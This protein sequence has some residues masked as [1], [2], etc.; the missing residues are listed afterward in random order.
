MGILSSAL[1][2]ARRWLTHWLTSLALTTF[3]LF[4]LLPF[5]GNALF[6]TLDHL[7][8]D[9][10]VQDYTGDP[11]PA[12][13]VVV[14]DLGPDSTIDE[15]TEVLRKVAL[16]RP[17]SVGIDFVDQLT[18]GA[19]GSDDP[20]IVRFRQALSALRS[21]VAIPVRDPWL[22]VAIRNLPDVHE[23]SP[24]LRKD[25]DGVVRTTQMRVC[26]D[27]THDGERTLPT[28]AAAV[29]RERRPLGKSVTGCETTNDDRTPIL[30]APSEP[31]TPGRQWIRLLPKEN[32][33]QSLASLDD[34]YVIIGV[35]ASASKT[36][37]FETP[38][39]RLPGVLVHADAVWTFSTTA[40]ERVGW[41]TNLL[42]AAP[43]LFVG[44]ISGAVFAVFAVVR[45][46][47]SEIEG[48]LSAVK[49]LAWGLGALLFSGVVLFI[50]GVLW[51]WIAVAWLR[52]G[53]AA[54]ALAAVFGSMLETLIHAG[55]DVVGPLHWTVERGINRLLAFFAMTLLYV[56][57]SPFVAHA[58]TCAYY[59]T[60]DSNGEV[61]SIPS[62][63][64]PEGNPLWRPFERIH[65]KA[66]VSIRVTPAE[67]S[68]G[69]VIDLP[70]QQVDS[71]FV[72]PP[73]PQEGGLLGAWHSFW[74][75]LNPRAST[76]ASGA[77]ILYKGTE[78]A[79]QTARHGPLRKLPSLDSATGV[80]KGMKGF[81]LGWA[82]GQPPFIINFRD[83]ADD[84]LL[85]R[86]H[87]ADRLLWLPGQEAP[88]KPFV[89][90]VED[91]D[92][93]I[94][95]HDFRLLP[96][97][98]VDATAG[99]AGAIE[100]FVLDPTYRMEAFRRLSVRSE[101]G[102]VTAEQA[103]RLICLEEAK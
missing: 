102:D 80:V 82:G 55:E 11:G 33:D 39:G 96:P 12:H 87:T 98:S 18:L 100:L 1:W 21:P 41:T 74:G 45:G 24:D 19:G 65:V 73:C 88:N 92:H 23:A 71:A 13:P 49:R 37:R 103:V 89:V 35:L 99:V 67:G 59:V 16:A 46:D 5:S 26:T 36:D 56:C 64:H 85:S 81:A 6:Q 38:I 95:R 42:A 77:T 75:A 47:R 63:A 94:I 31:T 22:W 34:A 91:R 78:D 57:A 51:T 32:L 70:P 2:F 28:L 66:D 53:V 43:D 84:S 68:R 54:G 9:A 93:S 69:E 7:G 29:F 15:L 48:A 83:A 86:A 10:V 72:L 20:R 90:T 52:T 50:I 25:E 101:A 40:R 27:D 76:T 8:A 61:G 44:M 58:E 79:E 17:R 60:T 62:H 3:V 14:V 30:F 97:A 4:L